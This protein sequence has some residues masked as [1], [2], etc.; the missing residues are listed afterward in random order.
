MLTHM[1]TKPVVRGFLEVKKKKFIKYLH[2]LKRGRSESLA[3]GSE[4]TTV[5]LRITT[6]TKLVNNY[7]KEYLLCFKRIERMIT[8][9]AT[10][11]TY[12]AV[13]ETHVSAST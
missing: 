4:L 5:F 7:A 12:Q 2:P 8:A 3:D 11:I 9:A 1:A 10:E 13:F 6:S